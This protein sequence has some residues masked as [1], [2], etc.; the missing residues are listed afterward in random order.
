VWALPG[1][2]RET[3]LFVVVNALGFAVLTLLTAYFLSLVNPGRPW[4]AVF[5]AASPTLALTGLINW[6]MLAVAL[7]A[8]AL[9]TWS[10]GSPVLT[11][12]LIGLGAAAKLYPLFLLGALLVICLRDRR[13][14]DFAQATAA[15]IVAW[16]IANAPAYLTGPA[17]WEVF[18][19]FNSDRGA[20]LGS[21]W[22]ALA[23]AFDINFVPEFINRWS[24]VFFI[25]WCACVLVVGLL[26]NETPRLAQLAFLIVAGFLL[27][28]KVYS[29]QYVLW[30]LPLAALARPRWRDQIIWQASEIFYFMSVWWYL[31]GYIATATGGD[32]PLYWLAI[33]LRLLGELYLI[34]VVA[35]DVL[36]AEHDVVERRDSVPDAYVDLVADGRHVRA[37]G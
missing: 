15:A 17:E 24:M 28:N 13:V 27:L 11:G 16:M 36:L 34:A 21:V 3:Q 2:V 26:A 35:R 37:T 22:L 5:F 6:D 30:L 14:M 19:S 20:D 8:A 4:D 31:G 9:W 32:P 29:P 25:V 1:M 33:T 23:Q 10:R 12:V 18:W 7:V